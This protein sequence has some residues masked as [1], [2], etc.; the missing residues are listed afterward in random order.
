MSRFYNK[1]FQ[2]TRKDGEETSNHKAGA[3]TSSNMM[4]EFNSEVESN[5]GNCGAC[6]LFNISVTPHGSSAL[7]SDNKGMTLYKLRSNM[8]TDRGD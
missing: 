4:R 8:I 5:T 2:D 6:E 3:C 7:G 1:K